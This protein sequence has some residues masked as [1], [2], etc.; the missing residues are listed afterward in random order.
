MTDIPIIFSAPMVRALLEGRKTMTRRLAQNVWPK[1]HMEFNYRAI[2]GYPDYLAGRDGTIYSLKRGAITPLRATPTS[3]G[4]PSVSLC[5]P[6]GIKTKHV[7][8]LVAA[9]WLGPKPS[10]DHEVRHLNSRRDDARLENLDWATGIENWGDRAALEN[11]IH[12]NHHAAK[13]T[14]EKAAEI[15]ASQLSQ[16]KLAAQYGVSQS[17]IWDIKANRIWVKAPPSSGRNIALPT[18]PRLWVRETWENFIGGGEDVSYRATVQEDTRGSWTAE[19]IAEMRWR[20]AI[21]MPRWASRLTLVVTATKIERLQ[22]ISD[23]DAMIEGAEVGYRPLNTGRTEDQI[24]P[25]LTCS[26][27]FGFEDLWKRLH[28]PES[29]DANPEVVA[30]TFTV[31]KTNIGQFGKEAA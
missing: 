3:R 30:L 24:N 11:G 4:Y 10:P 16:R 2:E 19:E 1:L 28:G 17:V 12:E 23:Y 7:H 8:A 13:L 20:P 25:P 31:H 5:G 6:E 26:Y 22:D 27:Q 15:R 9:A 14:M 29:W 18:T 21:H